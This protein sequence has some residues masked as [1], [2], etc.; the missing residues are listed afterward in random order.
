MLKR[1]SEQMA[2]YGDVV[3]P[4]ARTRAAKRDWDSIPA[5]DQKLLTAE[6]FDTKSWQKLKDTPATRDRNAR[7]GYDIVIRLRKAYALTAR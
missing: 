5:K 4:P 1:Y 7:H 3:T 2:D 6:Y